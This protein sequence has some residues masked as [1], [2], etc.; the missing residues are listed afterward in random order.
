MGGLSVS[1]LESLQQLL[2]W[3]QSLWPENSAETLFSLSTWHSL[4]IAKER[5]NTMF[6]HVA[7][8]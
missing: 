8:L 4:P 3:K 6:T 2:G 5:G 7:L 1:E